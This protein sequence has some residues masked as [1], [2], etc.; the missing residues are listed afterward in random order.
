MGL[1]AQAFS[2]Q[3]EIWFFYATAD[4]LETLLMLLLWWTHGI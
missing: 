1:I 2:L 4:A 3:G